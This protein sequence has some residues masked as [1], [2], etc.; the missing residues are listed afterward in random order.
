M[1]QARAQNVN[2]RCLQECNFRSPRDVSLLRTRFSVPAFFTFIDSVASGV[3]I[4]FLRSSYRDKAHVTFGV[5]GR[6][7]AVDFYLVPRRVRAFNVYA[8]VQCN[9]SSRFF[10]SLDVFL[11]ESYTTF[12]VGDFNCV[13]DQIRGLWCPGQCRSYRDAGAL[14]DLL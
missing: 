13:A 8:P 2:V 7:I 11:L 9:L 3:G 6:D 1:H 12:L 4:V 5:D 14:Q 10:A